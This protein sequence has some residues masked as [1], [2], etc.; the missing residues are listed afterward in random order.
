MKRVLSLLLVFSPLMGSGKIDLLVNRRNGDVSNILV[1]K[2]DFTKV[3][4]GKYRILQDGSSTN[5]DVEFTTE[6]MLKVTESGACGVFQ[7]NERGLM[8]Y[9]YALRIK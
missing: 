6:V 4:P 9:L 3:V 2:K 7:I 5:V 1:N 8:L